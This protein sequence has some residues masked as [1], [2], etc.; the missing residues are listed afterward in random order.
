MVAL[1]A[2]LFIHHGIIRPAEEIVY[3]DIVIICQ[4]DKY[5]S[6]N[7][8]ISPL[9]VAV[10]PLTAGENLSHDFLREVMVFP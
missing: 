1:S 8:N 7:I 10:Y 3:G 2:L 4:F 6:G 5:G 9:I